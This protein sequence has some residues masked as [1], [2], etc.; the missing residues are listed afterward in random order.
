MWNV[1]N[2]TPNAASSDKA[3]TGNSGMGVLVVVIISLVVISGVVVVT[4]NVPVKA[5]SWF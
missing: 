4:D 2:A 1:A 5:R 3:N